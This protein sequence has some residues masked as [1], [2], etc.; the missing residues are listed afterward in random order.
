MEREGG[1]G[2]FFPLRPNVEHSISSLHAREAPG[3]EPRHDH[4]YPPPPHTLHTTILSWGGRGRV[5]VGVQEQFTQGGNFVYV[6][7]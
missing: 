2:K 1:A 5:G 6:C 4:K 7:V 3:R